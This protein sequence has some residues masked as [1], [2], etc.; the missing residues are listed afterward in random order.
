MLAH[1]R[2]KPCVLVVR[3]G[4]TAR[5]P[6]LCWSIAMRW[7]HL[8]RYCGEGK[9]RNRQWHVAP[10][11]SCG[12]FAIDLQKC[13]ICRPRCLSPRARPGAYQGAH[14]LSVCVV[15]EVY[16]SVIVP[17]V[18]PTKTLR[19][20]GEGEKSSAPG[21]TLLEHRHALDTSFALLWG[22]KMPQSSVARCATFL[23]RWLRHRPTKM[24]HMS[25]Q[26]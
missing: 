19:I 11:F 17:Y 14:R 9:C 6:S 15:H 10:R 21:V 5:Q 20:G 2:Q 26:T 25:S 18:C 16:A 7:I 12:G 24:Y 4:R 8:S 23:L 1:V 22:G 13:T 3:W